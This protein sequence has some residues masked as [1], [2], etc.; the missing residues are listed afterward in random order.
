MKKT[1]LFTG[2]IL[3]TI[4]FS[5]NTQIRNNAGT[6]TTLSGFYETETPINYPEGA[7]SWWHLLD[8]RHSNPNNNF[9]MQF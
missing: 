7:A 3:S 2:V 9:G 4:V 8:V 6:P 5:Q 1:L